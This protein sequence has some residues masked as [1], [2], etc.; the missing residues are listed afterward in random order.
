MLQN[1]ESTMKKFYGVRTL[2]N[3][4]S[5]PSIRVSKNLVG[6]PYPLRA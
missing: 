5:P 4:P 3:E 2:I 6:P 1:E